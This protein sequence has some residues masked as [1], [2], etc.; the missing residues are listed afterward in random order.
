MRRTALAVL[1]LVIT[2]AVLAPSTAALAQ[3]PE[4]LNPGAA[5]IAGVVLPHNAAGKVSGGG[6]NLTY[7][8]GPVMRTN[9]V[10]A[11]YV[12]PSG[13]TMSANY[14]S[15]INR[16]FTDVAA[17]T[18]A[19]TTSNVYWSATQFSDSTGTISNTSTFGGSWT[20]TDPLPASGCTSSYTPV[21]LSD[22][23]IQAEVRKAIAANGWTANS[24]TMFFVFTAKNI[25]SCAGSS[26]AFSSYCAYHSWNLN[27]GTLL[28]ANM[29]YASTV[30]SAC[31]TGQR[32]NGD[33]AD[34][35]LNVTSHEHLE[36]ITDPTGKGW[37]DN[38]GYENGDKCAWNFGTALGGT[39]GTKYNQVINGNRYFLQQEWS[40]STTRCVLIGL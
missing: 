4:T 26:C 13:Y 12:K 40:N 36:G 30:P 23:Q 39:T 37:W 9:T 3:A 38:R 6:S 7:H 18:T 24:T 16:Y 14:Q 32:P 31:D 19:R 25:G 17:A 20:D 29:P 27:N 2:G 28:Y 11:I 5:H 1:G 33:D 34:A 21:C 10:Y 35:T 15:L 22:A 8:S